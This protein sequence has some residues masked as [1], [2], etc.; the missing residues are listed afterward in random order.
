MSFIAAVLTFPMD[1]ICDVKHTI[2][3]HCYAF[4]LHMS[5][6]DIV[7]ADLTIYPPW[8]K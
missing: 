8:H 7:D 4:H 5:A 1:R 6:H 2:K 3:I